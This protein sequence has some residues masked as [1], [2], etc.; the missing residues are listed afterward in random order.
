[1]NTSNLVNISVKALFRNPYRTFLTML[2]II[3]GVA[4]VIAM[5]G[6]GQG[7]K[8]SIQSEISGMGSNM[9]IVQP[10]RERF[11]GAMLAGSATETLTLNDYEAIRNQA[12]YIK[13][14][15]P[16]VSGGGQLV[17]GSKNWPASLKGVGTEYTTIS[18]YEIGKG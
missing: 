1:M 10:G 2:G 17:Y 3:I 13:E 4:S 6:I 11:R 5:L 12:H 9:L 15:S 18:K 16:M 8:Q 14:V 7:S